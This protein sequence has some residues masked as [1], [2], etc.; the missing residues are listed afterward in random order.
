MANL[1]LYTQGAYILNLIFHFTM[2][3]VN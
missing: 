2:D 3:V 1:D